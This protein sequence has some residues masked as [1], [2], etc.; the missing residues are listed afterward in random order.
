MGVILYQLA[1]VCLWFFHSY[2]CRQV[3]SGGVKSKGSKTVYDAV[4]VYENDSGRR[5]VGEIEETQWKKTVGEKLT[6]KYDPENP[7]E[8]TDILEPSLG[9]F[10]VNLFFGFFWIAVGI[11]PFVK[12]KLPDIGFNKK[13][14]S[15]IYSKKD[16]SERGYPVKLS[17]WA[18][19]ESAKINV[20]GV[21]LIVGHS[22]YGK[23]HCYAESGKDCK[24]CGNKS[25]ECHAH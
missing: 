3:S 22:C 12:N 19:L 11:F 8:S 1:F 18:V 14:K 16:I 9:A 25:G 4:Y 7:T 23:Q 15:I 6:V 2:Q 17:L 20:L 5:F 13:E 21:P 10:F 24:C